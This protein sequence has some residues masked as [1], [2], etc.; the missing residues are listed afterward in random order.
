MQHIISTCSASRRPADA[1]SEEELVIGTIMPRA[2]N[3]RR[4][5]ASSQRMHE[6]AEMLVAHT[7]DLLWPERSGVGDRFA[8]VDV[9]REQPDK[10]DYSAAAE[11]AYAAY[12]VARAAGPTFGAQSFSFVAVSLCVYAWAM[13]SL[14]LSGLLDIVG[15]A[16]AG[17]SADMPIALDDD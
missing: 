4:I 15:R 7:R 11:R 12:R 17:A 6:Q 13:P 2:R 16:L 5:K 9:D 3:A 1:I 10:M 14:T 8:P